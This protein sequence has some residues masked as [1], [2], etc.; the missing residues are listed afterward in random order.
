MFKKIMK[1]ERGL[2]LVELLAVVVI[3]AV[4]A[5]IGAV[6]ISN[7]IQKNREDAGISS[8]Q[9]VMAAAVLYQTSNQSDSTKAIPAEGV[10]TPKIT[11]NTLKTEGFLTNVGSVADGDLDKI[12]F[13]IKDGSVR[14]K[15]EG[16]IVKAGSK[17][18]KP[19]TT[20]P[21]D[22][23]GIAEMTRDNFYQ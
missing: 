4:I 16:G 23:K 20:T 19:F 13:F 10:T 17:S 7:V 5:G 3:M 15:L 8:M 2:S 11:A 12:D 9:N 21:L 18:N 6:A 1:D 14:M 22:E